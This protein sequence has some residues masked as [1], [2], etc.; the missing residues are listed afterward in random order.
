MENSLENITPR[1][2]SPKDAAKYLGCCVT[3]LYRY[4]EKYPNFPKAVKITAGK[5]F[6]F[7]EDLDAWLDHLKAEA[8][9]L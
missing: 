3:S 4:A 2:F 6:Y 5:A 8:M 9:A 1:V 7:K